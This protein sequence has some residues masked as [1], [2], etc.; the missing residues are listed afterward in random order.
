MRDAQSDDDL[1]EIARSFVRELGPNGAARKLG[2]GRETALSLAAG[3]RVNRGTLAL[4][5]EHLR[6]Q[7]DGS[8]EPDNCK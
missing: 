1:R 5:R 2:V 6:S 8:K 3:A 7:E 4:V